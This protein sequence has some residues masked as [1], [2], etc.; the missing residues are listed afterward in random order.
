M[1]TMLNCILNGL[2]TGE[3]ANLLMHHWGK[4]EKQMLNKGIHDDKW[5]YTPFPVIA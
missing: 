4:V 2:N 5:D 1:D 3:L